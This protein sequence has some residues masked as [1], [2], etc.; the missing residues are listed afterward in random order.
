MREPKDRWHL[1][2]AIVVLQGLASAVPWNVYVTESEY[3]GLRVHVP[4]FSRVLA[5]NFENVNLVTSQAAN[6]LGFLIYVPCQH[7]MSMDAQVLHPQVLTLLV[8]IGGCAVCLALQLGGNTVAFITLASQGMSLGIGLSGVGVASISFLTLWWS[9]PS[10][11]HAK[12]PEEI[13]PEA[14]SYFLLSSLIIAAAVV[15]YFIFFRMPFVRHHRQPE[16][17][18]EWDWRD[19]EEGTLKEPLIGALPAGSGPSDS[20]HDLERLL[21]SSKAGSVAKAP[22]YGRL[23][24]GVSMR[25][26]SEL[27]LREVLQR[28]MGYNVVCILVLLVTSAAFPGVTSA[29]CSRWN[30]ADIAPCESYSSKG[31]FFGDLFVPFIFLVFNAGDFVGRLAAGLEPWRSQAPPM[32]FL[33]VYSAARALIVGGL[34]LC[35]VVT[36][37]PWQLPVLL[38]SDAWPIGLTLL[39]GLTNGHLTSLAMMHAPATL[40]RGF[41]RDRCGPIL[42]LALTIGCTLGSVIAFAITYFFQ[43]GS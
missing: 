38:K 43:A 4:P 25:D 9:H 8:M 22:L 41:A 1:V 33:I 37:A 26:V 31:R 23:S 30:K 3:F 17:V 27:S 40:P 29:M 10:M 36:A 14:F 7:W 13:A 24:R 12:T 18:A 2:Y 28:M 35:N 19:S 11:K 39:L 16:V 6:L 20:A 42:N 5:D 21:R 32:A 15:T 34:V